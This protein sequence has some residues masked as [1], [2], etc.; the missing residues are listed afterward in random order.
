MEGLKRLV[1]RFCY[2]LL[3]P[4]I[5]QSVVEM[6]FSGARFLLLHT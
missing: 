3:F 2:S 4:D 1:A 6:S 5:S